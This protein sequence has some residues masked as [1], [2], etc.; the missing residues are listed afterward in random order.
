MNNLTEVECFRVGHF[1]G[2]DKVS[3]RSDLLMI[4]KVRY[5]I[6]T[7]VDPPAELLSCLAQR[8]VG[9]IKERGHRYV[10]RIKGMKFAGCVPE[11]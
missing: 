8:E 7:F 2:L 4:Y 5:S 3:G 6:Q 1:H 9:V 10:R 11:T